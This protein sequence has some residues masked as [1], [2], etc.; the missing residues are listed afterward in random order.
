MQESKLRY[1]IFFFF[2]LWFVFTGLNFGLDGT[3]KSGL[4]YDAQRSVNKSMASEEGFP[5]LQN[6]STEPFLKS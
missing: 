3:C 5:M 1:H 2:L 4:R 6:N